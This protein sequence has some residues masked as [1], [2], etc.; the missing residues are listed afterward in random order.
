MTN[1]NINSDVY[2]K[3]CLKKRVLPFIKSHKGSTLFWPDLASCHY[4]MKTFTMV[5]RKYSRICA[6]IYQSTGLSIIPV[7]QTYRKILGNC[8][9]NSKEDRKSCQCQQR[10]SKFLDTAARKV[11]SK[12]VQNLMLG[13][14]R[15]MRLYLRGSS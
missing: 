10:I 5:Q 15:K 6:K 3:E 11:S 1:A 7:V 13:I 2:M 12:V 14:T 8:Q 9:R 4:S